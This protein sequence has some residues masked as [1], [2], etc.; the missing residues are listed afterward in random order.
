MCIARGLRF[1]IV[2][3]GSDP[4]LRIGVALRPVLAQ[5]WRM[6]AA[7]SA[8]SGDRR[9]IRSLGVLPSRPPLLM[10]GAGAVWL[11]ERG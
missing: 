4:A 2:T 7:Q 9:I 5:P 10:F 3:T 8:M 1:A 11:V 6:M